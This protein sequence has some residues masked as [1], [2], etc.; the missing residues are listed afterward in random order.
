MN[1][2]DPCP[3]IPI[4]ARSVEANSISTRTF[5]TP[6]SPRVRSVVGPCG[7]SLARWG[8]PSPVPAFIEPIRGATRARRSSRQTPPVMPG[9]LRPRRRVHP[10]HQHLHHRLAAQQVRSRYPQCGGTSSLRRFSLSPAEK[11]SG[12]GSGEG[13]VPSGGGTTTRRRLGSCFFSAPRSLL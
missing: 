2:G 4:A 1:P 11:R 9:K 10:P 13:S 12:S 3:P 6:P 5:P 7:N 8:S